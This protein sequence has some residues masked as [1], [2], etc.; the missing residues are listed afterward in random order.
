MFVELVPD[1]LGEWRPLRIAGYSE[2]VTSQWVVHPHGQVIQGVESRL[3]EGIPKPR[4]RGP[5]SFLWS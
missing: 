4:D 2:V 3:V 5:S 1:M